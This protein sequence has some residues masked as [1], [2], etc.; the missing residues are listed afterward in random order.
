[1]DTK[2]ERKTGN[3][4]IQH[5][6]IET[7]KIEEFINDL[8]LGLVAFIQ[9]NH[10]NHLKLERL[11]AVRGVSDKNINAFRQ[12]LKKLGESLL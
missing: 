7:P 2:I 9:F 3:L 12:T 4:L 1:M 11:S 10:G 5:L 6:H 8:C